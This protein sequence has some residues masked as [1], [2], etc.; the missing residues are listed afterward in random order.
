MPIPD[1]FAQRLTNA[2]SMIYSRLR[3]RAEHR[4]DKNLD[5]WIPSDLGP[6]GRAFL[7]RMVATRVGT[8]PFVAS[9][10]LHEAN[11]RSRTLDK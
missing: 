1:T 2:A 9:F 11:P 6:E 3:K 4:T 8:P 7:K 10:D 5:A